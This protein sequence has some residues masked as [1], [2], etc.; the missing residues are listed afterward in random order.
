MSGRSRLRHTRVELVAAADKIEPRLGEELIEQG[1]IEVT[2]D[3][4][5]VGGADLD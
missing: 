5:H 4:E 1:E 3:G 2:G